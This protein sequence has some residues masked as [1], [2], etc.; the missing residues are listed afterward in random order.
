MNNYYIGAII[1]FVVAVGA[2]IVLVV[3]QKKS[4]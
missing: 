1:A 2:V 4:K 3:L